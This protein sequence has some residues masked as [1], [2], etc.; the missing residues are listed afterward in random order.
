MKIGKAEDV[1]VKQRILLHLSRFPGYGPEEDY[2]VP[3]DLTQDG[4]ASVVG[5]TRAHAS[6]DL[7]K[8]VETDHIVAWQAHIKGSRTKRFVYAIQPKGAL[9]AASIKETVEKAGMTVEALLD[10]K[11]CDPDTKWRSLSPADRETFGKACVLRTPVPRKDLPPT[12][13]GVVPTD[14]GGMI[15]ISRGTADMFL[16]RADAVSLR[17]WHCWAADYW[18]DRREH[19]ERLFHLI[20]AGRNLEANW[21]AVRMKSDILFSPNED[22][23]HSLSLIVPEDGLE[24]NIAWLCAEAAIGCRDIGKA[25]EMAD[26][27]KTLGSP[28][29]MTV[30]SQI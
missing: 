26:K 20:K 14:Y 23:L 7:K 15:Q 6:I 11:R 30:M 19:A 4:I 25:R 17:R 8:L 16:S 13:T 27:L 2:T 9:E 29:H 28:E 21:L 18:L 10:M 5:I 12:S 24:K 22:L 3:F 1:T